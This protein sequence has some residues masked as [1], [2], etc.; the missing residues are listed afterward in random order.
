MSNLISPTG[1]Y[2]IVIKSWEPR[3]SLWVHTPE[4]IDRQSQEIILAFRDDRW[5][6]EKSAWIDNI[7]VQLTLRKYPGNHIPTE[8]TIAIDCQNRLA[9]M[10]D[11]KNLALPELEEQIDL[12]LHQTNEPG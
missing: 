7:N 10:P 3:M 12:L 1:V 5:S 8:I 9:T 2:E 6:L 4:I 11:G